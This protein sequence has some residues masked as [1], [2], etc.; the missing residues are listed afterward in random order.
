MSSKQWKKVA[1]D[2]RRSSGREYGF[3]QNSY[4]SFKT[5]N[6]YFFC[7]Y[8]D[9]DEVRLT[10][11]PLYADELWWNVI[12]APECLRKPVSFRG[13]GQ[14]A[15]P[16][17]VLDSFP[18]STGPQ[19]PD[20]SE[21]ADAFKKIFSSASV[22]IDEFLISHPKAEAFVP[23]TV[24]SASDPDGLLYL[25]SLLHLD[26][27]QDAIA[28]IDSMLDGDTPEPAAYKYI[29]RWMRRDSVMEK[30]K[31]FCRRHIF[32]A[33][34]RRPT[35]K[36]I[37]SQ[38]CQPNFSLRPWYKRVRPGI[39]ISVVFTLFILLYSYFSD[40]HERTIYEMTWRAWTA[41]ILFAAACIL[42]LVGIRKLLSKY[43]SPI[44]FFSPFVIP[45]L[46][47]LLIA[48]PF[49]FIALFDGTNRLFASRD[50]YVV[51]AVITGEKYKYKNIHFRGPTTYSYYTVVR[52]RDND[53][54]LK[55]SGM[56]LYDL[57][58]NCKIRISYRKGLFGFDVIDNIY[59][60]PYYIER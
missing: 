10:V 2:A 5:E 51:T 47:P 37:K 25:I 58:Q 53:R 31:T 52:L 39:T 29:R 45:F 8:F 18:L 30:F 26:R 32:T 3:R 54:T 20:I 40:L 38:K 55:L 24:S 21:I 41:W 4:I 34:L 28:T 57:P 27:D 9:T 42:I 59:C 12:N 35:T 1:D 7:L 22:A 33:P 14:Y 15:L 36:R 43:I 60:Y 44:N 46:L 13:L 6:G 48:V 50:V 16:G 19:D 23:D 49:G 17:M 11:K 56:S